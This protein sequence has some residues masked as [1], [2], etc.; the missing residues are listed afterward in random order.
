MLCVTISC[1]TGGE[2]YV[3]QSWW[4]VL[5]RAELVQSTMSCRAG[6]E[7]YVVQS[8]WRV[9][10]VTI[11]SELVESTMSCRAG[12]EYC[13]L[14]YRAELVE[15]TMSCRDGGEYYVV[16]SWWRVLCRAELVG[17][18]MSCRAG[19]EDCVSI[20]CSAGGEYYVV[21]KLAF[22]VTCAMQLKSFERDY[23]RASGEFCVTLVQRYK[24][25]NVTC[26]ELVESGGGKYL[27][28]APR[29]DGPGVLVVS[30]PE[31]AAAVKQFKKLKITVVN[32]EFILTG[33]LRAEA[34]VEACLM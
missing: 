29:R 32:T 20:S 3:V 15:S 21:H 16:Q 4:R 12:E 8:W 27:P 9:L 24:I 25:L 7:Y 18:T 34:N 23:C 2:Y 14:L 19:G 10:C 13:V 11:G 5:C 31:D 30:C 22:N 17:S 26:A 28:A 6:G 1:K 33:I